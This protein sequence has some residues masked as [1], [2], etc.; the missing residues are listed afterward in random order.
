[1]NLD[2]L[3][4]RYSLNVIALKPRLR[5]LGISHTEELTPEIIDRLDGLNKHLESGGTPTEFLKMETAITPVAMTGNDLSAPVFKTPNDLLSAEFAVALR[6][7]LELLQAC[8]E[9]GW[10]LPTSAVEQIVGDRP[11]PGGWSR[12]GFS[13]HRVGSHG[14]EASWLITTEI[15]NDQLTNL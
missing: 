6:N 2:D 1:M 10:R 3:A 9:H 12:Y 4:K 7:R 15:V 5:I 13:F 11:R 8:S 14:R